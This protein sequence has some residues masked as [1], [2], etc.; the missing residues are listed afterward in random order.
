MDYQ[1]I[2]RGGV[3]GALI[4]FIVTIV[5][6]PLFVMASTR[7]ARDPLIEPALIDIAVQTAVCLS[8]L[9]AALGY[10]AGREGA[11]SETIV[12]ACIKGAALFAVATA[13]FILINFPRSSGPFPSQLLATIASFSCSMVAG[14]ALAS[15]LAAI[16]VRDRRQFGR[17]RLI[18]QFT[19]QEIFIVFTIVSVI[20]SALA[21]SAVLRL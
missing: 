5:A 15:G 3:L 7:G 21:S 9:F 19:L 4:A 8:F 12:R 6:M 20:I 10:I 18:P 17:A 1:F 16:V 2:R 14:G 11:R 13:I